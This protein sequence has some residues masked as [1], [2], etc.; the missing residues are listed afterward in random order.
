[1]HVLLFDIDGTLIDAHG[2]GRAAM[3]AALV[4]EFRAGWPPQGVSFA[5]R[6]D[7]AITADLFAHFGIDGTDADWERFRSAYLRHLPGQLARRPGI[8]LPGIVAL[9]ER[10][11]RRADVVLGLL[12]GNFEHGARL[13]LERFG[14]SGFFDF[15]CAGFGDR[16]H[17]RDDVAREVR[18]G[19]ER[20]LGTAYDPAR[21]IVVG[22]TPADVRCGRAIGARVVAVATGLYDAA[23]LAESRPDHL[24]PHF[25][26]PEDFLALLP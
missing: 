5:G 25:A 23:V 1:M 26:D 10:L 17:D 21:T 14:L 6:T 20:R 4:E 16:H 11:A 8:V 12:T 15:D 3:E 22:D 13:K 2:A 24:F 18:A 9:C 19:L 7:R